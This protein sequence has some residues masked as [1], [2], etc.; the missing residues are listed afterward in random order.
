[1]SGCTPISEVPMRCTPMSGCTPMSEIP[2]RYTSMSGCT[3]VRCTPIR[4][5][6]ERGSL[7][8]RPTWYGFIY[9]TFGLGASHIRLYDGPW[10]SW[11]GP[12]LESPWARPMGFRPAAQARGPLWRALFPDERDSSGSREGPAHEICAHE[13]RAYR[14]TLT[15]CTPMRCTPIGTCQ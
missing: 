7:A 2:M 15:R 8:L 12:G 11:A 9:T 4:D 3:L 6:K 13:M 10:A 5:G 1:M 14:Y